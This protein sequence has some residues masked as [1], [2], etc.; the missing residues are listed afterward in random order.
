MRNFVPIHVFRDPSRAHLTRFD[1]S[2]HPPPGYE[3]V[4]TIYGLNPLVFPPAVRGATLLRFTTLSTPPYHTI[5]IHNAFSELSDYLS[6][7]RSND[8]DAV[9]TSPDKTRTFLY[10]FFFVRAFEF[11]RPV[12]YLNQIGRDDMP[13]VHVDLVVKNMPYEHGN[14]YF[15]YAERPELYWAGTEEGCCVPSRDPGQYQTLQACQIH[16]YNTRLQRE[17]FTSD[18]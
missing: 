8:V 11:C 5:H 17:V 14:Q 9:M 15:F 3:K 18:S 4:R 10:A 7:V 13:F 12:R 6:F 16:T 1:L 2:E